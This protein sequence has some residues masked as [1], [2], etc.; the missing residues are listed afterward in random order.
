MA[1]RLRTAIAVGL[2]LYV[3]LSAYLLWR[4]AVL[5]PYS[6]EL[7]W[8]GRWYGFHADH[9]WRAY[10]FTPINFHRIALTFALIAFDVRT[11]GGTNWPLILSG[12]VALGLMA[13]ILAGAAGRSA[14]SPLR[15]PLAALAAM[16]VLMAGNVLDAATPICVDYVHGAA[17]A[18]AAIVLAEGAEGPR[19]ALLR[20]LALL[21]ALAAP[22]GDAAALAVWPVLAVSALRRRAWAWLAVVGIM[23]TAVIALYA[24]GQAHDGGTT[25]LAALK[26]PA[27]A[28]R[29]ALAY[30]LLP[31]S[32]LLLAYAWV[33]GA[34]VAI[35][36]VA[37]VVWR[38]EPRAQPFERTACGLILFTLATAAMAGLG[39]AGLEDPANV[40]LRYAVLVAP[41]QVGLVMLAGPWLDALWR[42]N[43]SAA[44]TLAAVVLAA[45]FLQDVGMAVKVVHASD[46]NRQLVADF[47]VGRRTPAMAATIHPDLAHAE[48]VYARLAHDGLFQ[49]E[50]HLKPT[51]RPR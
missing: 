20:P 18:V 28:V 40:P 2:G 15:L 27:D 5:A 1:P 42:A 4:T 25:A 9:D 10:L 45:V 31:W 39:R 26:H 33:G 32:R 21:L 51:A 43:R 36:A 46:V 12:A 16:I 14:A 30:L 37:A 11:F 34:V 22:F 6:D 38:G 3:A 48:A 49:R 23:G 44:Q 24:H 8:I 13:W 35:V 7:D 19:A 17:L 50:L 47:K 41:L 29:L